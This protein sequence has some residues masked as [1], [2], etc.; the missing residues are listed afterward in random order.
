MAKINGPGMP[1]TALEAVVVAVEV[2][3][4]RVAIEVVLVVVVEVVAV[5]VVV[6]VVLVVGTNFD[7]Q[8]STYV[9]CVCVQPH[10]TARNILSYS[11]RLW[12]AMSPN[13]RR[14]RVTDMTEGL[15]R[16]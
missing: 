7:D 16:T 14:R 3:V 12:P 15:A 9:I 13:R 1:W 5:V 4:V 11:K 8:A 10:S 2:G 6:V